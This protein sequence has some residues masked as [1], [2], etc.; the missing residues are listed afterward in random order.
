M[1]YV[2]LTNKGVYKK[3]QSTRIEEGHFHVSVVN[4]S[5]VL[6]SSVGTGRILSE[7]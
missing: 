1:F 2:S 5:T 7:L 3:D 4:A 6:K